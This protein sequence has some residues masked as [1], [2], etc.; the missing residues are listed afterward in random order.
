MAAT[1]TKKKS[2]AKKPAAKGQRR[3]PAGD[4]PSTP[5]PNATAERQPDTIDDAVRGFSHITSRYFGTHQDRHMDN[6]TVGEVYMYAQ[7]VRKQKAK[8]MGAGGGANG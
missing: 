6:T 5:T 3:N 1:P 7:T 4:P 2:P 8:A